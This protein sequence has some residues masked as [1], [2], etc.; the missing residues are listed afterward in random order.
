M[1]KADVWS[2]LTTSRDGKEQVANL[3]P[4]GIQPQWAVR[5]PP[6]GHNDGDCQF[7]E[8]AFWLLDCSSFTT[9]F[10]LGT[11]EAICSA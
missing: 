3:S 7:D 11:E 6:R 4:R 2:Q 8:L 10:T 5:F 1:P 9:C